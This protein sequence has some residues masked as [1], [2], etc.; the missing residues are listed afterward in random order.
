[1][2]KDERRYIVW[3]RLSLLRGF[4]QMGRAGRGSS[5]GHSLGE[6]L[7]RDFSHTIRRLPE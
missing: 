3:E 6:R 4:E 7:V 1:M 5:N 2:R